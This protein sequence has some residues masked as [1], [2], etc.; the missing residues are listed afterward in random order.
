MVRPGSSAPASAPGARPGAG[1][2]A[3]TGAGG[4][5]GGGGPAGVVDGSPTAT[6]PAATQ[7]TATQPTA[8]HPTAAAEGGAG[9][10]GSPPRRRAWQVAAAYALYQALALA[11]WWH[12]L[13]AGVASSLPAGSADPG[14][15]AWFLAWL[16]H[17]LGSGADPFLTHA[18]F[19]PAGANLLANTSTDLIGL[20]L[21]PVTVT[22]G[23]VAA[24]GVAALLGPALSATAAFVL[25]R[26]YVR[27]QP[28]AFVGALC[29]GFGPFLATDLRYGHVDLT[30]LAVPPLVL[31]CLDEL[32]VRRRR[33]P[34]PVGVALG[35]LVVVQFFI[36][37]ELLAITALMVLATV[38]M[39]GVAQPRAVR[40]AL[41][42]AW[43]GL[44]SATAVAVAAL[45]YPLA[46]V[47]TGPRH[48]TGPVWPHIGDIATSLAAA[49]QPHGELAGVAFVSGGNGGYLG[50]ALLVVLAAGAVLSW[51]SVALRMALGLMV[52]AF[53]ASLGYRL[54]VG[55]SGLGVPLPA[56][57]LGHVPLLESI[58]PERFA[59]MVDLFAGVALALVVD[60][61]RS[62]ATAGPGRG[63][64]APVAPLARLRVR[65]RARTAAAAAVAVVAVA[66][67]AVLP[68]WPYPVTRVHQPPVLAAA[69]RSAVGRGP[70]VVVYPD[71]SSAVSDEMVWQAED[72][73]AFR[74][75]DGYA[76]VP[77]PGG[78]AVEAPPTNALWLV[79]AA[80][81]VHRLALPLSASTRAAVRQDLRAV[82]ASA[83]V[84]LPG[85][86][87]GAALRRAL[88]AVLGTPAHRA[89]GW[90]WPLGG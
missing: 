74:L 75:A 60:R 41:A 42:H 24:L 4:G 52:V 14:Q 67:L 87:N 30:W 59:A 17:A 7:P 43:T 15:E 16:P 83:V 71:T 90:V 12:L 8:T 9:A 10:G 78:R 85:A 46:V 82:H 29:Y 32:L 65:N 27:W 89:T 31:A 64:R 49:V 33:R 70:V 25:C 21:A 79:L 44:A 20:L 36:S 51:R 63:G 50:V 6:Q 22:A 34:V 40:G 28:A 5:R 81:S 66:P 53:V 23:P 26:R 61:V 72:G 2:A 55:R 19:A 18:V 86:A 69:A 35:V 84:L 3:C 68:R 57:V 13:A 80:A 56:A 88:T 54:H 39:A 48:T 62:G 58:V 45:A 11:A 77:G 76:I 37:T 1:L 38:V 47:V 73:F